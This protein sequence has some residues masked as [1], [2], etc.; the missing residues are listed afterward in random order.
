MTSHRE[1]SKNKVTDFAMKKK[2]YKI[3]EPQVKQNKL[4]SRSLDPFY[5]SE[6]VER[7]LVKLGVDQ[8][9]I[10]ALI[11]DKKIMRHVLLRNYFL[12]RQDMIESVYFSY[13]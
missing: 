10:N 6:K 9:I 11:K 5:P 1:E 12:T 8:I 3:I 7:V 2:F 4:V 13:T